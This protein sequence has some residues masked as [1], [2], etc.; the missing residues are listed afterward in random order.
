LNS[1]ISQPAVGQIAFAVIASFGIA[2]FVFK[3]FLNISYIW[4]AIAS[5]LV[6]AFGIATYLRGGVLQYLIA[7]HPAT[8]FSHSV[9][10]ILPVQM[11]A[12]GT[13]GS[14]AGYWLAVRYSFWQKHL[15]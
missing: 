15:K 6:T 7:R 8:F 1:V 4:P 9:L 12:F 13:L 10:S 11:V 2:A 14:I 3:K 5:A